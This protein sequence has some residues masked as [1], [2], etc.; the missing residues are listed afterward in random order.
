MLGGFR[1][2]RARPVL[3]GTLLYMSVVNFLLTSG[4][5]LETPYLLGRTGSEETMGI[6]LSVMNIG[7][8]IGGLIIGVWGGTRPRIHTIMVAII[9]T[10]IAVTAFGLV[11]SPVAMGTA[12]FI[13]MLPLPMAN[14][15]F[16][17]IIQVKVAPD[18][19]GRVFAI[20]TQVSM[21]LMPISYLISGPL[22][23][24][25]IAP[26]LSQPVW[27]RFAPIFGTDAGSP[28]AVMIVIAGA[29]VTVISILAYATPALRRMEASLPDYIVTN[30]P[31]PSEPVPVK[32]LAEAAA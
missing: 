30:E 28:S 3:L 32:T 29:L 1:Y 8:L 5:A 4:L 16:M 26:Q 14:A 24:Q 6:L 7:G 27:E 20:I 25:V 11:R 19:Q 31:D 13:M 9:T 22:V 23:D 15:L 2:L 12:L 17:S 21:V 18:I 10:G